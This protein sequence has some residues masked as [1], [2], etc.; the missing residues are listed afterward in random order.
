MLEGLKPPKRRNR[1]GFMEF[2]DSLNESD[3][4]VLDDALADDTWTTHGLAVALRERGAPVTY[5]TVY[6][7]RT[8]VCACHR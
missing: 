1:C 5:Q 4:Q 8:K 3:L 2:R 6:R 7:H